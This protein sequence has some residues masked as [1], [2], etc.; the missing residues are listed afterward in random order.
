[1]P[2]KPR[3]PPGT[4]SVYYDKTRNRWVGTYDAG[5]TTRGT[6]RRR[7]V[8]APTERAARQKLLAAIRATQSDDPTTG[9]HPTIKRWA[10]TWETITVRTLRPTSWQANH[11]LLTRW[12]IPTIGHRRL[13]QL[14]PGDIRA[15]TKAMTDHGLAPATA[16]R[17][18]A[19]LIKMLRDARAEG[20]HIP[21]AALDTK[22]GSRGE[23]DRDAIPLPDALTILATALQRP[24]AARWVAALLQGMRPAECRGLTWAAIDLTTGTVDVSWQAK[25]LP[26]NIPRDRDSGF[27][28]P[29]GY[30]ARHLT[31][32]WHLVRPKTAAGRRIIP[33][34]PWMVAALEQWRTVAPESRWGL[35]WPA[36][37]GGPRRDDDDRADWVGLCDEARVAKVDE[38]LHGRRYALYEARHT[39]ATL[40]KRAKVDDTTITA[41]MGHATILSTNPYLHTDQVRARAALTDVA[42]VFGLAGT[43]Q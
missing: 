31:G 14:T 22:G 7:K 1:M 26:Y 29:V 27:R 4:G 5:W 21:Q 16:R 12:I 15:I 40:L 17:A 24:D 42:G 35:V 28:V 6:R 41:I 43:G 10:D 13:D 8:T 36:E 25:P 19:T 38:H 33:L 39:T 23:T 20:H 34:V 32:A 2:D 18:H 9:G 30:T 11:S 37:D 3:R